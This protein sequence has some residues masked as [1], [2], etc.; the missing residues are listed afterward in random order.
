MN[1]HGGAR[2]KN[3]ACN[4]NRAAMP[5]DYGPGD[6]QTQA[7]AAQATAAGLVGAIEAVENVGKVCGVDAD[8]SIGDGY[9]QCPAG[10]PIR[11]D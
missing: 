3:I 8:S 6:G 10:F 4:C 7:G 11:P 9:N 5:L 1:G 2:F